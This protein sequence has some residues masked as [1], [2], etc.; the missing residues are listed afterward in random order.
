MSRSKKPGWIAWRSSAARE[1][2]L[3]DLLP[4][5][6]ILFGKDHVAP[7]EVWEFYKEQEGFQNV[8]FDQFQERLKSHRKQ[9]S[10]TYVKSREE[11]A[12]LARDRHIYPR[13]PTNNMG[14]LVFDMTPARDLMREDVALKRHIGLTPSQLQRTRPEY[15]V[16]KAEKFKFIV[17][18]I[19]RRQ[20]YINYL[21]QKRAKKRKDIPDR[22]KMA[23]PFM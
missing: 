15:G 2:L 12:A 21:Q 23:S 13:Q 5:D 10:K 16:F 3:D 4:P 6:G 1:I 11:E 22:P 9:V 14:E 18:Q 8:V 17:Y 20:K 7:E 19:I